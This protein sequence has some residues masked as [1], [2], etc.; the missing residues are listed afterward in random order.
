MEA[1]VCAEWVAGSVSRASRG[2]LK[3][4]APL[5]PL[6]ASDPSTIRPMMSQGLGVLRDRSA[7]GRLVR[8][9]LPIAHR[10]GAASDPALVGL[11]IAVA[12]YQREESRGGHFRTDYPDTPATATPSSI[13][14]SEALQAAREIVE[15]DTLS[16]GSAQS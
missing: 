4:R 6:P 15:S 5:T 8:G 11:M 14:L 1:I 16:L 3:A 9:L 13:S 10:D 7:I 12:A 2:P